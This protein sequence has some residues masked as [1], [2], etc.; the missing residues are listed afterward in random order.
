MQIIIIIRH[1]ISLDPAFWATFPLYNTGVAGSK[2]VMRIMAVQG[3][4]NWVKGS[5]ETTGCRI[6]RNT[7]QLEAHT[8][9]KLYVEI[10]FAT[11][12]TVRQISMRDR[13]GSATLQQ[14]KWWRGSRQG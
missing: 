6:T 10:D 8:T 1:Y 2:E 14:Q 13:D 5:S 11:L 3:L 4:S 9:W 7:R 12:R